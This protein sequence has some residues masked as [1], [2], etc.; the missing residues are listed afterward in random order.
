LFTYLINRETWII[1]KTPIPAVLNQ[2]FLRMKNENSTQK[3]KIRRIRAAT[4]MVN[5]LIK[6]AVL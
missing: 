4:C 6:I 5:F 1:I 2:K 3:N